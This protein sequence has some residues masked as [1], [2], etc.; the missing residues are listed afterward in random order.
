MVSELLYLYCRRISGI[1]H[2]VLN[3]EEAGKSL[4]HSLIILVKQFQITI[5]QQI[6]SESVINSLIIEYLQ[7]LAQCISD[8]QDQ[9]KYRLEWTMN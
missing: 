3:Y 4:A 1:I 9:R 8:S 5:K 2:H 7:S 6:K